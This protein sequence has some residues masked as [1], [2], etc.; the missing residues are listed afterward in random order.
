MIIIC[1]MCRDH[2]THH[3]RTNQLRR[4]RERVC[5]GSSLYRVPQNGILKR[6]FDGRRH[7]CFGKESSL[8]CCCCLREGKQLR[9]VLYI[10]HRFG[11]FFFIAFCEKIKQSDR[12]LIAD[13]A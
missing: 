8:L 12:W 4:R 7:L 1:E 6:S 13:L 5:L 2:C 10:Y 9:S 3:K 11:C